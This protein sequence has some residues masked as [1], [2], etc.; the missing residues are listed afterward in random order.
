MIFIKEKYQKKKTVSIELTISCSH[1]KVKMV[2]TYPKTGSTLKFSLCIH[3]NNYSEIIS[4]KD[5]EKI[6]YSGDKLPVAEIS[7]Q[8][9]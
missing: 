6:R 3:R 2:I 5:A 8:D 4:R 1:L 7:R 9:Q